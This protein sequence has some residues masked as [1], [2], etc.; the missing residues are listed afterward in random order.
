[1]SIRKYI[2]EDEFKV[3]IFKNKINIL[4]YNEID[5]IEDEK[6]IIRHEDK[7]LVLHGKELSI[8]KLLEGEVLISGVIDKIEFR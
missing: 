5:S 7:I 1:M 6:I 2:V 3:T 4:N 8:K